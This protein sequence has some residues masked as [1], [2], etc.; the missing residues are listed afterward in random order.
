[1]DRY[2]YKQHGERALYMQL[3]WVKMLLVSTVL[4]AVVAGTFKLLE[5]K[6]G[7]KIKLKESGI[8]D[9]KCLTE[10]VNT[11][12]DAN[13]VI[14]YDRIKCLCKCYLKAGFVE[15]DD[16]RDLIEMH[17]LYHDNLGGNGHI[18]LLMSEVVKLPLK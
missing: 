7:Y 3:E 11:L 10:C 6:Y 8:K 13:R 5:L 4:T 1:M 17:T 16:R 14:L 15:Y 9:I 12:K 2:H 18:D